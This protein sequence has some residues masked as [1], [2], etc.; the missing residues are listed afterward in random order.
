MF[1]SF[2]DYQKLDSYYQKDFLTVSFLPCY[3]NEDNK[4]KEKNS[5]TNTEIIR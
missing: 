5:L 3:E 1:M 2:C 4:D